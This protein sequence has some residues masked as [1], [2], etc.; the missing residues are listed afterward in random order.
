M[1]TAIATGGAGAETRTRSIVKTISWRTAATLTTLVISFLVMVVFRPD[2]PTTG[3]KAAGVI[4]AIEVPSKLLL[5]YFHERIW[6]QIPL[7]R[8]G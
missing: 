1:A 4:A 3:A 8:A 5:Y 6:V 7:G 2:D